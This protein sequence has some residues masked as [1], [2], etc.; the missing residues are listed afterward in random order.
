MSF[1]FETMDTKLVT[2][3]FISSADGLKK[4]KSR[5]LRAYDEALREAAT[6][7]R[8]LRDAEDE[9]KER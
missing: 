3:S 6:I 9:E 4:F 7:E 2:V 5:F 1:A 8:S